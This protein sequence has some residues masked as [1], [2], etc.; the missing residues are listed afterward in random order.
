MLQRLRKFLGD[1]PHERSTADRIEQLHACADGQDWNLA[2]DS[3][4]A[5]HAV[6]VFATHRHWTRGG[7]RIEALSFEIQ[8]Q[9]AAAQHEAID[10]IEHGRDVVGF[11]QRRDQ[12]RKSAGTI[13]SCAWCPSRC[14]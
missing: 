6:K 1:V 13:A 7:M 2:I 8:V 5:K 11:R 3:H 9:I 12:K 4:L 10:H 14:C